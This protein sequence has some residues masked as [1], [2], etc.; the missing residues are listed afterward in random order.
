MNCD[1]LTKIKENLS[2]EGLG[3]SRECQTMRLSK[4]KLSAHIGFPL[5]TGDGRKPKRGVPTFMFFSYCPFCG[6]QYPEI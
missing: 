2:K 6:G 3:I 4:N 1:C 5:K